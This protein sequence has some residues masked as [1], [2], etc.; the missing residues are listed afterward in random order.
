MH[1]GNLRT[2]LVA[3]L[4]ARHAGSDFLLRIEDL[5]Q[6]SARPEHEA[7]AIDHLSRLGID[8][9]G[10]IVRQ[11]ERRALHEDA[12]ATLTAAG[13]TY[14][15][16]CSR[17]EM[18]AEAHAAIAAPHGP[19]A[20]VGYPGT[21]RDLSTRERSERETVGRKPSLRL[22]ADAAEMSF[23]D[24]LVG[25]VS[26]VVDDFVVRRADGMPAYNVVVVVDDQD[27]GVQEVVR[28]DDLVST[29]PRQLLVAR[30]L[31]IESPTYA[32]VPLVLDPGGER[33]AKRHGAV[34]L[35]DQNS[36]GRSD[37]EILSV[38]AVSLGLADANETVTAP[39]LVERFM[40]GALPSQPWMLPQRLLEPVT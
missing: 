25:P 27:Q 39:E 18:L 14:P 13:R 5:D 12:L 15:C 30:M 35:D 11:S 4:F 38:L 28:G 2:A 19:A 29:T 9:D 40:I 20:P 8:W 3:W 23:V 34:T 31:G 17:R 16:Y 21:C 6:A 1:L 10:P 32:H 26:G 33:L 7:S 36:L 24:Q 37:A 22:R